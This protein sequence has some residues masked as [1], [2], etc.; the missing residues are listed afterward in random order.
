MPTNLDRTI[1]R[2]TGTRPAPRDQ[3]SVADADRSDREPVSMASESANSD[4][5]WL[6]TLYALGQVGGMTDA[7]LV[8]RFLVG[9]GA[10]REDAFAALVH[11]HGRMVLGVCRRM[12]PGS[13]D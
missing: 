7:Q 11:R 13:S 3:Y 5:R 4:L 9:A 2:Q 10:D 12:L 8:E 6:R 1:F